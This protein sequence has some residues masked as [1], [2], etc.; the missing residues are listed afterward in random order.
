M[1]G[2]AFLPVVALP[3]SVFDI[4]ATAPQVVESEAKVI[5]LARWIAALVFPT[6]SPPS[7]SEWAQDSSDRNEKVI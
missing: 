1:K 4:L 5:G 3:V 6:L 2:A 7:T